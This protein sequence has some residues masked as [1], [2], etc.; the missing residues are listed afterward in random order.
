MLYDTLTLG[1]RWTFVGG[2]GGVGKTTVAAALAVDLAHAGEQVLVVSVDP[3]H[4]LGDALEVHL[5]SEPRVVVGRLEAFEVDP[6]YERLRFFERHG[7]ALE[8]LVERG[9][10]LD[11]ADVELAEGLTMP[12]MDEVAAL[13]RF[14]HI[15]ADFAGRIIVDTAPTGHT[16]RLLELPE[17]AAKW[18]DALDAMEAKHTAVASAL[19]GS[20]TTDAVS[21]F[22][23]SVRADM[24]RVATLLHDGGATT[25]ILVTTGEPVV[26]AET[27]TFLERLHQLGI[28]VGGVVLNRTDDGIGPV[29]LGAPVVPVPLLS[30]TPT[31]LVGLQRYSRSVGRAAPAPA[32]L[33]E[34]ATSLKVGDHYD[35]PLD[36]R[37]Y[38][39]GGKGGVGKSTVAAALGVRLVDAGR[40]PVLLLSVDPAGSLAEILGTKVGPFTSSHPELPHLHTRQLDATA[41]WAAY[42]ERYIADISE[43]F[44]RF[45]PAAVSADLDRAV[46]ERLIDLSPPG[47]DE[48]VALLEVIDLTED[49]TYDAVF[50]DTAPT[51]HLL[52]LLELPDAALEWTHAL[53]RLLLKYREAIRLG[54]LAERVLRLAHDLRSLRDRLREKESTFFLAVALP[55]SLS[56]PETGRLLAGVRRTGVTPQALLVNRSLQSTAELSAELLPNIA[57]LLAIDDSVPPVAAPIAAPAPTGVEAL[58]AFASYW[59]RLENYPI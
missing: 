6:D 33:H 43:L 17:A 41:S 32:Q 45:L 49:R 16:L 12:G 20:Y 1:T 26:L 27:R 3:A 23:A 46:L 22:L 2:K 25:F 39:V 47:L 9:T 48:L 24:E 30:E 57:Q 59:R 31:G 42:R 34:P 15:E 13:L 21:D 18:L 11:A 50:V 36:R 5:G 28:A 37:L 56:I 35:P 7:P 29:D 40:L 38:L 52:R 19:A 54:G 51:G 14:A 4:S 44:E 53:L 55:E 58:R 8:A 10:Y